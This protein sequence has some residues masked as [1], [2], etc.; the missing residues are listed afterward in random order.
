MKVF[1]YLFGLVLFL[2]SCT[3]NKPNWE[4]AK[5]TINFGECES[6]VPSDVFSVSFVK[7]ETDDDC[8]IGSI[9][10]A[11]EYGGIFYLLDAF[12]TK[13]VFAFDKQGKY[14]VTVLLQI[15]EL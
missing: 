1:T 14:I 6:V 10:Q 11:E 13:T 3:S 15:Y 4:K 12:I 7:L 2:A 9:T 8:L 5:C